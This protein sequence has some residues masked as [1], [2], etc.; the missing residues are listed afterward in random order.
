MNMGIIYIEFTIE[1]SYPKTHW[2]NKIKLKQI[3]FNMKITK[4]I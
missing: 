1:L 3:I 4:N 2:F